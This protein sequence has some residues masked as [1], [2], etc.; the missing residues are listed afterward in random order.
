MLFAMLFKRDDLYLAF[1]FTTKPIIIGLII[2]FQFIFSPYHV[3]SYRIKVC[4][5][6]IDVLY[7]SSFCSCGILFMAIFIIPYMYLRSQ[8]FCGHILVWVT[9]KFIFSINQSSMNLPNLEVLKLNTC[10]ELFS[11]WSMY[12]NVSQVIS[13]SEMNERLID[14]TKYDM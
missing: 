4:I 1:G 13:W 8:Q 9:S 12:L 5:I 11:Y 10:W 14:M 2:I 6:C 3:V 7:A